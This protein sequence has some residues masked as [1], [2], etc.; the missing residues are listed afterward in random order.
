MQRRETLKTIA[1]GTIST[2]LL[3]DACSSKANSNAEIVSSGPLAARGVTAS[4]AI[5][6]VDMDLYFEATANLYNK[7]NNPNGAFPLNVAEN[8]LT[9]PMLQARI[10]K[11][12]RE[13][14][15]DDWVAGY[16]SSVGAP[17]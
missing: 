15:V 1:A 12:T 2:G 16:T 7:V 14:V 8:R 9:W 5:L 10:S 13:N 6:R 17:S 4:T 3:L 11:I